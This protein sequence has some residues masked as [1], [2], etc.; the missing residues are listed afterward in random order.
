[1]SSSSSPQWTCDTCTLL[2]PPSA[3]TCEVCSSGRPADVAAGAGAGADPVDGC[4]PFETNV[5]YKRGGS[6]AYVPVLTT[7]RDARTLLPPPQLSTLGFQLA[8]VPSALSTAEFRSV[9]D[10]VIVERYYPEV[11]AAAQRLTGASRVHGFHHMRRR[12]GSRGGGGGG[13]GGGKTGHVVEGPASAAHVDY[14]AHSSVKMFDGMVRKGE[15]RGKYAVINAWRNIDDARPIRN[16]HLAMCDATTIVAPDDFVPSDKDSYGLD[17]CHSEFHKWYYFP[18]M[19]KSEV[20]FFMQY[21][22]NVSAPARYTFHSSVK[23]PR[24]ADAGRESIEV[25]MIAFFPDHTPTCLPNVVR[26]ASE[27]VTHSRDSIFNAVAHP[28]HWPKPAK[29]WMLGCLRKADSAVHIINGIIYG[30]KKD[31]HHAIDQLTGAQV[32]ELRALLLGQRDELERR[33]RNHFLPGK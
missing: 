33:C 1:M 11:V 13:G 5:N 32:E 17:P 9:D 6:G 14:T 16:E 25:R 2:N 29:Q 26:S 12:A 8:A 30:G 27:K 31:G 24:Q 21:D 15:R 23:D 10:R 4:G 3:A 28:D 20:L 19:R 18:G 22:S 7:L